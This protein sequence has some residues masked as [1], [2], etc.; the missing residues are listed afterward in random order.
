[1][2]GIKSMGTRKEATNNVIK[3]LLYVQREVFVTL[4]YSY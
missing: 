3:T 4:L 2:I 1:M